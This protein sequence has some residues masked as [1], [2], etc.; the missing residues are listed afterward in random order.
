[1]HDVEINTNFHF[2]R[3]DKLLD[4]YIAHLSNPLHF[5]R[6]GFSLALGGLPKSL[7]VG[8]LDHVMHHLTG[9]VANIKGTDPKFVEARR[10]AI[11]AITRFTLSTYTIRCLSG[12]FFLSFSP[13]LGHFFLLSV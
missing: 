11:R 4:C 1:M 7:L 13:N 5:A 10:D 8:R 6:M 12:K 9:C 2:S 3:A